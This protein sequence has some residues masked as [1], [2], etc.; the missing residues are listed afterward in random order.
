MW[1]QHAEEKDGAEKFLI[2]RKDSQFCFINAAK[3]PHSH[4]FLLLGVREIYL[5]KIGLPS[6]RSFLSQYLDKPF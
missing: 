2:L 5:H 6:T 1:C 4:L 3:Q